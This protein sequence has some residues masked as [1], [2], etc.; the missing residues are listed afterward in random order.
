MKRNQFLDNAAGFVTWATELLPCLSVHLNITRRGTGR[1]NRQLGPGVQIAC[2]NF[3]DIIKA[4]HWRACWI[5]GQGRNEPLGNWKTTQQQ[6]NELRE[7]IQQAVNDGNEQYT[8]EAATAI[9]IWGGDIAH[10][11]KPPVGSAPFLNEKR[12]NNTLVSYFREAQT[13]FTLDTADTENLK[14]ITIMNSM[15]SKVHALLA[16]D[17]LP[18]YDSRVAAAIGALIEIYRQSK[19]LDGIPEALYFKAP[20]YHQKRQVKYLCECHDNRVTQVIDPGV[21]N[22]NNQLMRAREWAS[23][24]IRLGW[25]LEAILEECDRQGRAV[26]EQGTSLD[27]SFAARMHALEA[28]LFMIGF[29]VRCLC[30]VFNQTQ[31]Q[32]S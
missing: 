13:A 7:W 4:Y 26:I 10:L 3:D 5:N 28:G 9:V 8:L 30:M 16:N 18:I 17:G 19:K 24:K 11:Q 15:L 27:E 29:D 23:A 20:F 2:T 22:A 31:K 21:I 32:I 12:N 6:L 1:C 14:D 25:L